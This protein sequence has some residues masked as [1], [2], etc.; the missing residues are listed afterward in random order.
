MPSI[1]VV[2]ASTADADGPAEPLTTWRHLLAAGLHLST[3]RGNAVRQATTHALLIL[4]SVCAVGV[5]SAADLGLITAGERG[6]YYQFGQDLKRL[7]RR[8]GIE[9]R[10]HPSRGSVD[11]M[12]VVSEGG[13]VKLGIVQ[14]DVLYAIAAMTSDPAIARIASNVRIVFP[15][16]NEDVH[17]IG[18][19]DIQ[20]FDELDGKRI[21]I[22]QEG[23]GTNLTARVLFEMAGIVPAEALPVDLGEGLAH[24]KAGRIDAVVYVAGHPVRALNDQLTSADGLALIPITNNSIFEVYGETQIPPNIYSWQTIPVRTATVKA[25]LVAFTSRGPACATIGRLARQIVTGMDWLTRRGH[26]RWRLVDLDARV[27][28]W[29]QYDCVRKHLVGVP[30]AVSLP[31]RDEGRR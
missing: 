28:G 30:G 12:R 18:R 16:F 15:L 13:D 25:V 21:A 24:L 23:S 2:G 19:A 3:G 29:Q 8:G 20:D 31:P 5:A 22:G 1:L 7:A 14:A 17:V 4:F 27:W 10:I 9:L 26:P 11:N 6:T